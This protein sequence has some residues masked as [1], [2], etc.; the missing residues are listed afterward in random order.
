MEGIHVQRESE[1][2]AVV[3]ADVRAVRARGKLWRRLRGNALGGL[4]F[5]RRKSIGPY[6]VDFY[7]EALNLA[8]QVEVPSTARPR[9][10]GLLCQA[11]LEKRG[12][13]V[14]RVGAD[15]VEGDVDVCLRRIA[16]AVRTIRDLS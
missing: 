8:V 15:E 2:R 6:V 9:D 1:K 14:V 3:G 10:W 13:C 4:S 11:E 7:A 16:D 5:R 12:A